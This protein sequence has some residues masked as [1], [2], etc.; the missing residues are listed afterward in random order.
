MNEEISKLKDA[1]KKATNI[2]F[3]TGAGIS[4]PSGIPDFR[5]ANGIYNQKLNANFSPEEIISHSFFLKYPEYFYDFYFKKMV[6]KDAKPNKAHEYIAKLAK[7]KNVKV[8]TQNIDG[9]HQVD[10]FKNVYE[11]HGSIMRNYCMKCGAFYD[12]KQI[13]S[14]EGKVPH[15]PRCG[16]LIKPDVVLYEEGLN[17]DDISRAI[18]A[19]RNAD[20]LIVVGTSLVVYPAAGFVNYFKGRNLVL[21]NKSHTAFDSNA[22]I[23]IND[24]IKNVIEFLEKE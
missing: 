9:L 12:L 8:I 20:M 3:F 19:I 23:L 15:C 21:I 11:I 6:Y 16:G 10:G 17:S 2:V 5:S 13:Y 24:D 1:I 22:D 14:K 4:V 7:T 18:S